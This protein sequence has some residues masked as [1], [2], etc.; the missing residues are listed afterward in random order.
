MPQLLERSYKVEPLQLA[1]QSF[2][3]QKPNEEILYKTKKGE[4]AGLPRCPLFPYSTN[5]LIQ[6]LNFLSIP[7]KTRSV[8]IQRSMNSI[9][10]IS[11]M[12]NPW[13]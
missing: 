9:P 3:R 5:D 13:M 10:V 6:V 12:D 2:F 4:D 8:V 11:L 1:L 7:F